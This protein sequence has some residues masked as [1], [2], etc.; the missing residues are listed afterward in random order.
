MSAP[1]GGLVGRRQMFRHVPAFETWTF[2]PKPFTFSAFLF[3][4]TPVFLPLSSGAVSFPR[5]ACWNCCL[6]ACFHVTTVKL[7]NGFW[8][9]LIFRGFYKTSASPI[10]LLKMAQKSQ[11]L[12]MTSSTRFYPYPQCKDKAIPVQAWA[13]P[14]GCWKLRLPDFKTVGTWRL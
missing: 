8:W 4:Y 7:L 3:K 12:Y 13:V 11:T 14:E 10:I 2:G 1:R 9:N 5:S 6:P